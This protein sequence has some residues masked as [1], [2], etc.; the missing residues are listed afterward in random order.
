MTRSR[1]I[2][3]IAPLSVLIVFLTSWAS[4]QDLPNLFQIRD[5]VSRTHMEYHQVS[6]PKGKEVVLGDLKGPG[7]VTYF[8]ITDSS[9]GHFFSGLVLKLF[10]D[11]QTL[12]SVNVPLA[13][14]FGAMG[15]RT[16]DYQSAPLKIQH[17]CYMCCLPMPFADRVRFVLANDGDR[18][19]SQSMAYGIDYEKSPQFAQEK[20]RLHSA[21][22][23]S[24]PVNAGRHTILDAKGR[25]HYVGNFL[26]VDTRFQGWF[27]EGDTVFHRDGETYAHSPG[28]ED[29]YGACWDFGEPFSYLECGYLEKHGGKNRMYRWYLSNPVRFQKSLKVEIQNQHTNGTPTTDDADDYTSIAY[30][31]QDEPQSVSLQPFAERTAP[32]K[33]G[34]GKKEAARNSKA[35]AE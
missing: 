21:W 5:A 33:A 2:C 16:I 11:G 19:Y 10:W 6:I 1:W 13:D 17:L 4:A 14:F 26:Q 35:P 15:G 8:Y 7:K 22:R 25:G 29:E 32:S 12:P 20:S 24:N 9:N 31:Y 18:D 23:R 27:G 30:W 3:V 28:T 34:S